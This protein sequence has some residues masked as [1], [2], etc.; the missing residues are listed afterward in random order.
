MLLVVTA[1]VLLIRLMSGITAFWSVCYEA[2]VLQRA[3][4]QGRCPLCT[5]AH[6]H[7]QFFGTAAPW[8]LA[9]KMSGQ[10]QGVSSGRSW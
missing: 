2:S 1:G 10:D 3:I 6:W 7:T 8:H 5:V 9:N 4:V